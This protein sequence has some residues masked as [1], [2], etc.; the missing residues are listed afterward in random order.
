MIMN[1]FNSYNNKCK[2]VYAN[3]QNAAKLKLQQQFEQQ[4]NQYQFQFFGPK[5]WQ[6]NSEIKVTRIG[7]IETNDS[8]LITVDFYLFYKLLS[9]FLFR[10][11]GSFSQKKER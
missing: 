2:I 6:P 5:Y 4:E 9:I 8:I 7:I 10:K 11:G 3:L 1:D